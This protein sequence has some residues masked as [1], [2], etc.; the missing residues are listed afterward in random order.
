MMT[1]TI[2]NKQ[3]IQKLHQFKDYK[4]CVDVS[5]FHTFFNMIISN[6]PFSFAEN[7]K[8]REYFSFIYQ[9]SLSGTLF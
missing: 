6:G 3:S 7:P 5:H 9:Q 2:L 1:K 8:T 4:L